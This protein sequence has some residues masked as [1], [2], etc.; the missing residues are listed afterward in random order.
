[1]NEIKTNI[2]TANQLSENIIAKL[3]ICIEFNFIWN[4]FQKFKM[5]KHKGIYYV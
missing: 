3:K 5:P 2:L 1:M 4:F